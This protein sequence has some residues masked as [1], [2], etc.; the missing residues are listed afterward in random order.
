MEKVTIK[1]SSPRNKLTDRRLA[2]R[3]MEALREPKMYDWRTARA[4]RAARLAKAGR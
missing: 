2:M 1:L 4:E 3:E